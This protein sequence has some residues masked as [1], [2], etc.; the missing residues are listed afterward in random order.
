[1]IVCAAAYIEKNREVD[2]T[3]RK[4][5]ALRQLATLLPG[6]GEMVSGASDDQLQDQTLNILLGAINYISMLD[7]VRREI[8][9]E[10]GTP[11]KN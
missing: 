11:K 2:G 10:K 4:F 3:L 8:E 1:M 5:Q 7:Q 6:N 9:P